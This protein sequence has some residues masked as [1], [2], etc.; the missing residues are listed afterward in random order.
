MSESPL[1]PVNAEGIVVKTVSVASSGEQI[2]A[3]GIGL[4][5]AGPLGALASWGVIRMFA[6][7]WTP[8]LLVGIITCI[9]L[10]F[11]QLAILAG[12]IN[13]TVPEYVA[14]SND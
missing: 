5:T 8:W 6:G 7:K 1:T 13:S 3:A 9:P 14:P 4:L 12:I 10:N 11:F 2:G